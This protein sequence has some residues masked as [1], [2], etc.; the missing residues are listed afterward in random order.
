MNL[1]DLDAIKTPSLGA[2]FR[3]LPPIVF[4]PP[5]AA[6]VYPFLLWAFHKV[7]GPPGFSPA[8]WRVSEAALLLVAMLAVPA[9][10][11]ICAAR[12]AS[13][14]S[15]RRLAYASVMAPTL[16]VFLGVLQSMARSPVPDELVWCV[17]WSGVTMWAMAS[18]GAKQ[19]TSSAVD[20]GRWRVAHGIAGAVI[21]FFV[22]F[23][24]GNH[25][26][27]L[28][29]PAAHAA[30]MNVGR[31]VYRAPL[32]EPL[33]VLAMLFQIAS[34]FY[35][36]WRWSDV[37]VGF[38]RL[39][40]VASGFYLSAYVL[41]H[42]NSVFIYARTYLHIPTDWAFAT[43]AP[44][45]LIHD[46]WNIRLLPHYALGVFFVLTHLASGLRVVLIAHGVDE[47]ITNQIWAFGAAV[48]A[49]IAVAIMAG[50]CGVRI[51]LA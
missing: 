14:P 45:G 3:R 7:V 4:V 49:V 24:L 21:L 40:Q 28:I 42:M 47:A 8:P 13:G 6:A 46:P 44:T 17:A 33:L 12:G 20:L 9:L 37:P 30:V 23:H 5:L 22:L 26:F 41:G 1:A 16:Y 19:A 25:L 35:L 15:I 38:H 27:G 36:A 11:M 10:G 29:G 50:M 32:I 43:G 31:K 48:S 18:A 39:F 2:R 34:G 51:S